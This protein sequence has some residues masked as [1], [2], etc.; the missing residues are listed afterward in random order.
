MRTISRFL[1]RAILAATVVPM[2]GCGSTPTEEPYAYACSA[3][4]LTCGASCA[5][6]DADLQKARSTCGPLAV[7]GAATKRYEVGT[8]GSFK[9]IEVGDLTVQPFELHRVRATLS[10]YSPG[11]TMVGNGYIQDTILMGCPHV[12]TFSGLIPDCTRVSTE[13]F[14]CR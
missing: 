7:G 12:G 2:M 6:F 10:F 13:T 11:G 3:T 1:T 14:I 4:P 9:Y 8:C 5:Q